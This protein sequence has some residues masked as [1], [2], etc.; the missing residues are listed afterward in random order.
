VWLPHREKSVDAN[1]FGRTVQKAT[2]PGTSRLARSRLSSARRSRIWAV[3]AADE[4]Q[5]TPK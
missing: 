3:D 2:R 4:K 1:V 5:A